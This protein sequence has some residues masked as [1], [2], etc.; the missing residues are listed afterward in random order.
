MAPSPLDLS[1]LIGYLSSLLPLDALTAMHSLL[2]DIVRHVQQGN[3]P[4]RNV[5]HILVAMKR[6][7]LPPLEKEEE[8]L[9]QTQA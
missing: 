5:L 2:T 9:T 3:L 1:F 4:P 8:W 6:K 7:M